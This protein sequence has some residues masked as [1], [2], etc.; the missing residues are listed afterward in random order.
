MSDLQ[1]EKDKGKFDAFF[2]NSRLKKIFEQMANKWKCDGA[3]PVCQRCTKSRRSCI[4]TVAAHNALFSIHIENT[5]ASGK[6]KRPR[7]PR[8]A[9]RMQQPQIAIENQA[10]A[11]YVHGHLQ[12]LK[13]SPNVSQGLAECVLSWSSTG[14][15][16]PMVDLALASVA[17]AVFSRIQKH[18]IAGS[19]ACSKYQQLLRLAQTSLSTRNEER[20][21]ASLLTVF[22][23]CRYEAVLVP[24]PHGN[25][26]TSFESSH[27]WSHHDGALAI[28]RIWH[29]DPNRTTATSIIK[30]SRRDVIKSCILRAIPV[31]NWLSNGMIFGETTRE[32]QCDSVTIRIANLYA[33]TCL[34]GNGSRTQLSE[35]VALNTEARALHDCLEDWTNEIPSSWFYQQHD[36]LSLDP[37][38]R[39]H[40]YST[41]VYSFLNAGVGAIWCQYFASKMFLNCVHLKIL[42]LNYPTQTFSLMYEL[43]RL[44][45]TNSIRDSSAKLAAAVPFCLDRFHVSRN[46]PSQEGQSSIPNPIILNEVEEVKPHLAT[47]VVWP[48]GLGLILQEFDSEQRKWFQSELAYLGK[49]TGAGVLECA[50]NREWASLQ[51]TTRNV[52][53]QTAVTVWPVMRTP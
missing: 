46:N 44:K 11:Y 37:L 31:P 40:F 34:L 22:L 1:K 39:R 50:D 9:L 48:L 2:S 42:D 29:D 47:L 4:D 33:T 49:V 23:V 28:L 12:T 51:E 6:I 26:K 19:T 32:T 30:H 45:C 14:I 18:P 13:D 7:G 36:F 52:A 20:V 35:V 53:V 43:E 16:C 10:V 17:L 38:P 24:K 5:F 15:S 3:R 8:S 27:T 41:T 25:S 21:D